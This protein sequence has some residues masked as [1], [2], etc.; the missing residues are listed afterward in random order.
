M[1]R[2]GFDCE[3]MYRRLAAIDYAIASKHM[4][5]ELGS[6]ERYRIFGASLA[7]LQSGFFFLCLAH[8]VRTAFRAISLR[9]SGVNF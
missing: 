7:A 9:R 8:R 3:W 2:C 1:I 5:Q 6:N 4:N